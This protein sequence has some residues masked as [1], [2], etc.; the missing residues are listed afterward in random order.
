MAGWRLMPPSFRA[1]APQPRSSISAA[2]AAF[3]A[4]KKAGQKW[5]QAITRVVCNLDGQSV[6]ANRL[7]LQQCRRS[8]PTGFIN[9]STVAPTCKVEKRKE[10][11]SKGER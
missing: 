2:K 5:N 1:M 10:K 4:C 3:G 7:L 11:S 8:G 9:C 6:A